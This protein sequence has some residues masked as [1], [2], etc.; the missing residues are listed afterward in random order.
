MSLWRLRLS[1]DGLT[2][3]QKSADGIAGHNVG[4]RS[5]TGERLS[6]PN[7]F[8]DTANRSIGTGRMNTAARPLS[9]TISRNWRTR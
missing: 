1:K 6:T 3:G 8:T 9:T 4:K 2:A 5:A 7:G